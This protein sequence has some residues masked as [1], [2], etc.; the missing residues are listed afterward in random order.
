MDTTTG[1]NFRL[2]H[3]NNFLI[4]LIFI[5]EISLCMIYDEKKGG[6]TDEITKCDAFC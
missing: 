1:R 2:K 3:N 4:S 6:E 5:R